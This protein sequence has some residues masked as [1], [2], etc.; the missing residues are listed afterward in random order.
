MAILFE[1]TDYYVDDASLAFPDGDW[2]FAICDSVAAVDWAA[3]KF[4]RDAN[5]ADD[6]T[7]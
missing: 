3:I 5:N 2:C 1:S 7:T 6:E 4:R